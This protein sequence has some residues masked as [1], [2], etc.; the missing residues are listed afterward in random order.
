M[1]ARPTTYAIIGGGAAGCFA[2]IHIVRNRPEARVTVYE[3]GTR[4]LAKVA[5][6]GGG[7]CNLTNSFAGVRSVESVYPRGHRLMRQLLRTFSQRDA[8]DWFERE[9]VRLVTQPDNCV[10][11]RSQDAMEIVGTLQRA[12]SGVTVKTRHRVSAL[13][14]DADGRFSLSFTDKALG[15]AWADRVVVATGGW[16][17]HGG[18]SF[19]APLQ[20]AIE[21]PVPSLFGVC[22][23]DSALNSLTGTVV[24]DTTVSLTGTKVRATG[25]LLITHWG[26]SGPAILKLS[27]H[28][29]RLL[30]ACDYKATVGVNWLGSA[31]EEEAME[32][33]GCLA[34]ANPAKQLA[35]VHP[36]PLNGRLWAVLLSQCG[37]DPGRRWSELGSKSYRKIANAL[38][39]S[40]YAI[41]GRNRFKEEFV[42]CGGV[43]LSG[44]DRH[45]LE[46]KAHPGLFFAGEALDIDAVTGGFNLQAAWTTG[47]VAARGA[48]A[49]PPQH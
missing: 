15:E 21:P 40:Q 23:R 35:T 26:L 44:I 12:L 49:M 17:K 9:G 30:H 37:M 45:T 16:P 6:T 20:V 47:Y 27:S 43:S 29:A 5:V 10:F 41:S 14:Q 11:P 36:A 3:A 13:R 4:L 7:R 42:T 24:A 34:A 25:P 8:M 46:S 1:T 48:T 2:A 33:V 22:V 18:Q 28:G 39:N 31:N 19:L 32:E 38:I